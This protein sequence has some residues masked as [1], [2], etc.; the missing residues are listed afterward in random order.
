MIRTVTFETQLKMSNILETL[1]NLSMHI[2]YWCY[3]AS[4]PVNLASFLIYDNCYTHQSLHL[5]SGEVSQEVAKGSFWRIRMKGLPFL[6]G[7]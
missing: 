3:T 7:L 4:P 5:Q 1:Y 2:M 6:F